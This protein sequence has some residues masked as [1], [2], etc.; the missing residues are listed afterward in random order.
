M[1]LEAL[2]HVYPDADVVVTHRDPLKVLPS[3][4]SF[5]KVLRSPFTNRL[6]EG[7]LRT[8]VNLRWEEGA[9]S[10]MRF[11]EGSRNFQA[12]FHDVMYPD[13]MKDPMAVVREIYRQSDREFTSG[14]ESA[15][16]RFAKANPKNKNGEHR[17]S[18]EQFGF[19]EET[20]RHRFSFYTDYYGISPE[21]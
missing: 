5:A 16:H 15:M 21:P 6:D 18:L 19:D 8:D 13:L 10:L 9:R 14:A 11:R 12:H 4:A 3:C 20:E 1:A 2:F 17:Y 7:A